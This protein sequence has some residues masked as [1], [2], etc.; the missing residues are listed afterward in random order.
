MSLEPDALDIGVATATYYD[1]LQM[2]DDEKKLRKNL[3]EW[4]R[5]LVQFYFIILNKFIFKDLNLKTYSSKA[6]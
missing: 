2:V 5:L 6:F 3:L 1:M 4:V